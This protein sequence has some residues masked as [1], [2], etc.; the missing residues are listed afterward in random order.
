MT[1]PKPGLGNIGDFVAL[2][3]NMRPAGGYTPDMMNYAHSCDVY[4]IW[5]DMITKDSADCTTE[6]YYC[7]FASRKDSHKY[8]YKHEDI[9]KKYGDKIVMCEEMPKLMHETMGCQMYTARLKYEKEMTDFIG[10]VL[11]REA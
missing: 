1:K 5:A 9:L 7:V 2:E 6:N 3:V 11:E 4:K 10:F 8:K